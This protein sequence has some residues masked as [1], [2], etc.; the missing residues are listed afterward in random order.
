MIKHE[1]KKLALSY[2]LVALA[3]LAFIFVVIPLP[4]MPNFWSYLHRQKLNSNLSTFTEPVY[5]TAQT[6]NSSFTFDTFIGW[7]NAYWV[8]GF[9]DITSHT[10]SYYYVQTSKTGVFGAADYGPS[11]LD[12]AP[13]KQALAQVCPEQNS[14]VQMCKVLEPQHFV[15]KYQVGDTYLLSD[16]TQKIFNRA[17]LHVNKYPVPEDFVAPTERQIQDIAVVMTQAKPVPLANIMNHFK[18]EF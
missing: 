13:F 3:G 6:Q 5:V 4:F 8:R 12:L 11:A 2:F 1:T 14:G 18:P 9:A 16:I 15:V 17:K 10:G 7:K